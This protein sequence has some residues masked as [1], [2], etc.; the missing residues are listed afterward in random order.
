MVLKGLSSASRLLLPNASRIALPRRGAWTV[1]LLEQRR[2]IEDANRMALTVVLSLGF[3][4]SIVTLVCLIVQRRASYSEYR[5]QRVPAELSDQSKALCE[6]AS[7]TSPSSGAAR[8]TG[9]PSA[10]ART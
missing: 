8:D 5:L 3:V 2:R 7:P 1:A 6:R 9:Q 4:I 10:A